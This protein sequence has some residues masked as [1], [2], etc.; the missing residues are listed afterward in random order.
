MVSFQSLG[1]NQSLGIIFEPLVFSLPF[2]AFL[3]YKPD[4]KN[5]EV[6]HDPLW[7]RA[8]QCVRLCLQAGFTQGSDISMELKPYHFALVMEK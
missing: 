7:L 5:C 1:F 6:I 3:E 2:V 4:R 8:D